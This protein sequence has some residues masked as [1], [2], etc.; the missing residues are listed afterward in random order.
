LECKS[1]LKL[2]ATQHNATAQTCEVRR[3]LTETAKR[4]KKIKFS[5]FDALRR[6]L[7]VVER[8]R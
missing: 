4:I 7:A 6:L 2:F 5:P 8:K 1:E 3:A